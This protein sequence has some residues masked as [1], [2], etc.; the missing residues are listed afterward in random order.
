MRFHLTLYKN[1]IWASIL[2][3]IFH[4]LPG[5]SEDASPVTPASGRNIT[6][7]TLDENAEG[8]L[9]KT[10]YVYNLSIVSNHENNYKAEYQAGFIHGHL[11]KDL[12]LSARD[13]L[14]DVA[15]YVDPAHHTRPPALEELDLAREILEQNYQYTTTTFFRKQAPL[16]QSRMLRL[17]FRLLG[18]YHGTKDAHP[19]ALDFSGNWVP[20]L[21]YFS[22]EELALGYE[23]AAVTFLDVY[24]VNAFAD[25]L[26]AVEPTGPVQQR[27]TA[28]VYKADQDIFVAHNS[29]FIFLDQS[30][31][32]SYYINGDFFTMNSV[33][34]G[35]ISSEASFGYNNKGIMYDATT[36][37]ATHSE[38]RTDGL[39]MFWR[40]TL[41]AQFAGSMDAFY[42]FISL[43]AS[44]TYMNSYMVVDVNETEI[45]LIE[46]SYDTFFYFKP[47]G[48]GGYDVITSKPGI[49]TA[50]DE[51]MLQPDYILGFNYPVS[52]Y[53]RDELKAIENRPARRYQLLSMIHTVTD[54]E[55]A[56]NL[57]TYTFDPDE[58]LSIFGRWDLGYGWTP[59]PHIVPEGSIDA[60]ATSASMISY[61]SDIKGI[62]DI[63]SP[64][65]MFWMKYGTPKINGKPF[66]WSESIWKDQKLRNVPDVVDDNFY[67]LNLNI[68]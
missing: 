68:R 23:T 65:K 42:D 24:F 64:Y 22:D 43:E 12:I 59:T 7:F 13:N 41:A 9:E 26:D 60:K 48:S 5:C 62:V 8:C 2:L 30:M 46:M 4:I 63:D 16:L 21:D 10:G 39:W 18:V 14:W 45:G 15:S 61:V 3:A 17:F 37:A 52:I 55:K 40:E 1:C 67:F 54:I 6:T 50:Y 33:V 66:I 53:L 28:F 25:Y 32:L 11:L 36:I 38:A 49:S 58:P 31:G 19:S 44:G 56:K 20:T 27:C 57:I 47:D 35:M 34:P 51:E 29:W